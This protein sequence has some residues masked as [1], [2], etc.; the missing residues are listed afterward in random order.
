[1]SISLKHPVPG[2]RLSDKFGHR[3]AI[4][5]VM[6]AGHHNGQDYAA[7]AGALIQAAHAGT[8]T[9]NGWDDA[10]G[11]W[12][13]KI[14]GP[15]YATLYL[16]MRERSPLVHVGQYVGVGVGIGY[17]GS[18]GN[19]TGPHLHFMLQRGGAYVDPLPHIKPTGQEEDEDM[20]NNED[21]KWIIDTFAHMLSRTARENGL[22]ADGKTGKTLFE[23]ID[24]VPALTARAILDTRM[25][26][27]GGP[28]G[29]TSLAGTLAWLDS[30]LQALM[31]VARESAV[32]Q[33]V[34]PKVIER[35]I[36]EALS[37]ATLPTPAEIAGAVVDE[38]AERLKRA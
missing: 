25:P 1:M 38:Q 27:H 21:K 18:S 28:K 8:V 15:G 9:Y 16:H 32:Q 31:A 33:G 12:M 24:A 35:A 20:L 3:P 29:E 7:G 37:T 26:R 4:P 36:K 5:G 10:G 30:N 11:G 17:V 19:S 14:D 22:S 23:K 6:P 2:A 13:V 34:D